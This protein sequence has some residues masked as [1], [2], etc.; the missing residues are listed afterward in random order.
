MTST[1]P[2]TRRFLHAGTFRALRLWRLVGL[3]ALA[4]IGLA[5][6][7]LPTR[8]ATID[9]FGP[10]YPNLNPTCV[11]PYTPQSAVP[12]YPS[13]VDAPVAVD[14]D[15]LEASVRDGNG[16]AT[17]STYV[18]GSQWCVSQDWHFPAAGH[19]GKCQY[20]LYVPN[21]ANVPVAGANATIVVGFYGPDGRTLIAHSDPIDESQVAGLVPLTISGDPGLSDTFTGI[22]IG[23]NNGQP[24]GS[25]QI[26]WG[27]DYQNSLVRACP[28]L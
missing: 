19:A 12:R 20:L 2:H 5:G 16:V 6:T 9:H 15:R 18:K 10:G 8:A 27:L 23:D 3:V 7:A 25:A 28:H 21:D 26:G 24:P 13:T 4:T 11:D 14:F 17:T 1:V 22:N